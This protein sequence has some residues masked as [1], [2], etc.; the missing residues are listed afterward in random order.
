MVVKSLQEDLHHANTALT[1]QKSQVT[2]LTARLAARTQG[3]TSQLRE[4]IHSDL[5]GLIFRNVEHHAGNTT[6][7]CL[8]IGRNGSTTLPT[9]LYPT[10]LTTS[11]MLALH[12][13]LAME[14]KEANDPHG[15][16]VY[17]PLLDP[18]RDEKILKVLPDY[19]T[20][21]IMFAREQGIPLL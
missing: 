6:F 11:L 19:L 14:D 7:D 21:E 17:T 3:S 15:Q 2:V 9:P 8:Q 1:D 18:D 16:I 20:D 10:P 13:K 5:S 12:Y 4:E